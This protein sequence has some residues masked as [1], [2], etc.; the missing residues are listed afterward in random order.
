MSAISS[1]PTSFS[2][3]DSFFVLASSIF[4]PVSLVIQKM[5]QFFYIKKEVTITDHTNIKLYKK[6]T[7]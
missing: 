4:G 7:I 6:N 1:M 2:M 5:S 3:L